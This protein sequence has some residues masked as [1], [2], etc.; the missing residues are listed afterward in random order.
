MSSTIT[1]AIKDGRAVTLEDVVAG[2]KG[3]ICYTCGSNL[4]CKDGKGEMIDGENHGRRST[5]KSKHFAHTRKSKCYGEGP[6]HFHFKEII[7]RSLNGLLVARENSS[8][9]T[10][11]G[12][13]INYPCP[14]PAYGVYCGYEASAPFRPDKSWLGN[15]WFDLF[16]NL[17][18][19]Q[20]E[21]T[22]DAGKTRP[23]LVGL[24]NAGNPIWIIEIY[25]THKT[26]DKCLKYAETRRIPVFQIN[27]DDI[28]SHP[29]R[30]ELKAE[31]EAEQFWL[32]ADNAERGFLFADKSWNTKCEREVFGMPVDSHK[33]GKITACDDDGN[34]FLLHQCGDD[35]CPDKSYMWANS[36]NYS[37]MYLDPEHS[38][39]SHTFQAQN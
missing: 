11:L 4:C 6:A 12:I 31:L 3:L 2:E 35:I 8:N 27:I 10:G 9:C 34:E 36:L 22:L 33:W 25:R 23:D 38:K 20:T 19:V 28:P 17:H 5:P 37:E 24:D 30:N 15:H 21:V 32:R 26:S 1:R 14:T 29:K 39:Q 18:V 13:G 7:A 16:R